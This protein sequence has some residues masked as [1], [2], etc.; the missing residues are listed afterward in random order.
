MRSQPMIRTCG[1]R[2]MADS[3]T[4]SRRALRRRVL[5]LGS[6]VTLITSACDPASATGTRPTPGVPRGGILRVVM[7]AY[8]G[9]ELTFP[10]PKADALD[11][12]VKTWLDSAELFRCCLLRTL[13]SYSGRPAR[14]GGAELRPDLAI[15]MPEVSAD[16]LTWTFRIRPR[17]RYAPPIDREIVA[18]DFVRTMQREARLPNTQAEVYSGHR[19]IRPVPEWQDEHHLRPGDARPAHAEGSFEPGG[20]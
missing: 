13:F 19:G 6:L 5:L 4:A 3:V 7:P 8:N 15:G 16:A 10:T 17:V 11:P 1:S 14:D 18:A 12:Q 2:F 20:W 9:S